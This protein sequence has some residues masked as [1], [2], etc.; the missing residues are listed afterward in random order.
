MKY[1]SLEKEYLINLLVGALTN[2]EISAPPDGLNWEELVSLAKKQQVYSII[3]PIM[4]KIDIPKEQ[5]N[6]IKLYNQN[7]LLRI[8]AMKNEL[9]LLESDLQ[10]S[11]I[12]YML[13]KGSVIRNYYPKQK[14]RQ[15]SDIDILYKKQHRKELIQLMKNR[16]YYLETGE[17]N[18]DDF[19]K[20]PYYKFEFH[21][22]IF[23][24]NDDF[25]PNFDLWD[26]AAMDKDNLSKHYINKED[27]FVY[28]LCH[29]YDHYC[30]SG[31]GIRFICDIYV[32]LNA[33]NDFDWDYINSKFDEFGF[34]DFCD[35]AIGLAKAIFMNEQINERQQQLLDFILG[36]GVYGVFKSVE[37]VINEDFNGSKIKYIFHRLFPPK[38]QMYSV[39]IEL[40]NRH[41]LL[42][43]FYIVRIF[44]KLK[45]KRDSIKKEIKSI[46]K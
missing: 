16:G 18:S 43:L 7:E 39:Y 6:E 11:G 32:L 23:D 24:K 44:Q 9:E 2:K 13:V 42:P 37:Q 28:S 40:E 33:I 4:S 46:S 27:V 17:A 25:S 34:R 15:M 12:E 41:Y 3:A 36:G 38:K 1:S 35:S 19:F 30:L 5:A 8:I 20:P 45:I 21:R 14:M 10:K 26:R 29:M 31:C 22:E